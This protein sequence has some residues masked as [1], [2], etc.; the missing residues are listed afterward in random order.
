M[1]FDWY[2]NPGPIL[3]IFSNT[4]MASAG[5]RANI[6]VLGAEPPAGMQLGAEPV[7]G[8]EPP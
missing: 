2:Q 1:G 5:A 8:A 7:Q 4:H 3:K 6:G